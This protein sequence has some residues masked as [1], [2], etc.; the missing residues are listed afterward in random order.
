VVGVNKD[1]SSI[2]PFG[3]LELDGRGTVVHYSPA[4]E[5]QTGVWE[6]DEIVGRNFFDDVVPVMPVREFKDRFLRFMASG[7]S[8]QRFTIRFPFEQQDVR[9]QI[10]LAHIT[11]RTDRRSERLALVRLMPENYISYTER[12]VA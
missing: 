1:Q 4:R 8:V 10:M 7:D 2:M 3:L 12:A 5:Q 9:V 11:E 6:R